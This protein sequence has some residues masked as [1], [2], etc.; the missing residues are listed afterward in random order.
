MIEINHIAYVEFRVC[1]HVPG[2][3]KRFN[4]NYSGD[5][6]GYEEAMTVELV[7]G[8]VWGVTGTEKRLLRRVYKTTSHNTTK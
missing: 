3:T 6:K 2:S 4:R 8:T 5:R 1:G 7:H